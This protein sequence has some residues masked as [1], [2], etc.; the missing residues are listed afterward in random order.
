MFHSW[1][2]GESIQ[3]FTIV[4]IIICNFYVYSITKLES[5]F[6]F[7]VCWE[8]YDNPCWILWNACTPFS[9]AMVWKMTGRE[10]WVSVKLTSCASHF[11]RSTALCWL[12]SNTCE[13]LFY[14]FTAYTVFDSSPLKTGVWN[15]PSYT[16]CQ[17]HKQ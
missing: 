10:S 1:N 15:R 11:L 16:Q 7:F 5:S 6:L 17:K 14:F 2:Q 12:L 3:Y 4:Y 13:Q 9:C 8:F